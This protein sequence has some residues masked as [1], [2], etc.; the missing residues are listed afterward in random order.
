MILTKSHQRQRRRRQQSG[1]HLICDVTML[2]KASATFSNKVVVLVFHQFQ[3]T[4]VFQYAMMV[5]LFFVED[6]EDFFSFSMK[7]IKIEVLYALSTVNLIYDVNRM[8]VPKCLQLLRMG[9]C[10]EIG[11]L[12]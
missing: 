10:R 3:L 4:D 12:I 8:N 5:S 2:Q 11:N 1:P 6:Q 7:Q 9:L